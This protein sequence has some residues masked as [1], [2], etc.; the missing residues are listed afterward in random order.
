MAICETCGN[1]YDRPMEVVIDGRS[2]IFD[3]FECAI[4]A[5]APICAHCGCRVIGHGVEGEEGEIYCCRNCADATVGKAV[6][7]LQPHNGHT[8]QIRNPRTREG[9]MPNKSWNSK[10]ERQYDHVKK[11]ERK[12]GRSSER[13][14]EIAARTVNKQRRSEGRT[15]SRSSRATG[16][17]NSRLDERSVTELRNIARDLEIA[18]RSSLNKDGLVEAIRRE[19]Q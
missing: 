16:N 1:D 19:R 15:A 4:H 18:G 5:M 3:S 6:D 13:A 2:R 17:P 14:E 7:A 11:S 10:D 8:R 9:V 12:R